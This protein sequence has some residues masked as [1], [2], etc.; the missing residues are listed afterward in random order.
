[1]LHNTI[2]SLKLK[3]KSYEQYTIKYNNIVNV[4]EKQIEHTLHYIIDRYI[5]VC[6]NACSNIFKYTMYCYNYFYM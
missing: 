3:K 5:F 6:N 1:M 2:N 4:C